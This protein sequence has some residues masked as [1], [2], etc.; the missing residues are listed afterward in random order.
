MSCFFRRWNAFGSSPGSRWSICPASFRRDG[1]RSGEDHIAGGGI[2]LVAQL[3]HVVQDLPRPLT[4][5]TGDYLDHDAWRAARERIPRALQHLE[6]A[7]LGVDLDH[8]D[9][10]GI[11][12]VLGDVLVE[13]LHRDGGPFAELLDLLR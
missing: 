11:D 4:R 8:A 9:F 12:L 10:R 7:A 2:R 13:C 1:L 3:P 5:P 6:L